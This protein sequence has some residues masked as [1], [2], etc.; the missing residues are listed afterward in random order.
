MKLNHFAAG[1]AVLLIFPVICCSCASGENTAKP[2]S[3]TPEPVE[4][5]AESAK[6][7]PETAPANEAQGAPEVKPEPAAAKEA[8]PVL[9]PETKKEAQPVPVPEAKKEAA[10]DAKEGPRAEKKA[11]PCEHMVRTGDNLWRISL[12][13]YGSGAQWKRILEANQDKIKKADH[14]EPGTVLTIPAAK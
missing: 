12:R 4:I 6:A 3:E 8:E 1:A 14:L 5:K 10:P 2:G 9:V 11:L 7:E 13:Y